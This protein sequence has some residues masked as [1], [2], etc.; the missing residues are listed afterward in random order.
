MAL[1]RDENVAAPIYKSLNADRN[2]M[3][4]WDNVRRWLEDLANTIGGG[5]ND[6]SDAVANIPESTGVGIHSLFNWIGERLRIQLLFS[7]LGNSVRG[8]FSLIAAV[9]KGLLSISAGIAEGTIKF[10]AGILTGRLS[11]VKESLSGIWSPI[12]GT[13]IV[14]LGKSLA[15]A[16]S[17]LYLQD[18]ERPLSERE[19]AV[20]KKVFN[21]SLNYYVIGIIE[22]RSGIFGLSDRAFTLGNTIYMKR[23]DFSDDL[24]VHEATHAWQYEQIGPRYTSDALTAQWFVEDAYN[25]QLEVNERGKENWSLLNAEAQAEFL[26]DLWKYGE[27]RDNAGTRVKWGN[28][29]FFDA[30]GEQHIGYFQVNGTN[31]LNLAIDAVKRVRNNWT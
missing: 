18:I 15:F 22:G 16:Q 28:G 1:K 9:I 2:S 12:A 25:W 7:W 26:E 29:S 31:Y 19:K 14:V 23:A 24:L 3:G 6:T 10:L 21:R 17:V 5:L 13:I 27:I 11:M 4:S 8:I 20:L 30:D